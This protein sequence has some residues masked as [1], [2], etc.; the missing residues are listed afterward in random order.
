MIDNL[1][2]PMYVLTE[3]MVVQVYVE[4][5]VFMRVCPQQKEK[6]EASKPHEHIITHNTKKR[7][8][9]PLWIQDLPFIPFQFSF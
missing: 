9:E 4:T 5:S 6:H 3:N 8:F 2:S 1:D 7:F